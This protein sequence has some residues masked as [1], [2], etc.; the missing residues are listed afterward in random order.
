MEQLKQKLL[1]LKMRVLARWQIIPPRNRKIILIVAISL[2]AF[3]LLLIILGIAVN[4][5]RRSQKEVVL[6]TPTPASITPLEG[7]IANP[8]RYATDAGVLQ[9]EANLKNFDARLGQE[10]VREEAL[11]PPQL[12]FNVEF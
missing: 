1:L 7:E 11:N 6:P 4:L 3:T 9:I 10:K 8:S 12:D 2:G 5:Q